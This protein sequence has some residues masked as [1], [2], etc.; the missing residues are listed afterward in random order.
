VTDTQPATQPCRRVAIR[1]YA[2]ASSPKIFSRTQ[3]AMSPKRL[4]ILWRFFHGYS[5]GLSALTSKLL[6]FATKFSIFWHIAPLRFLLVRKVEFAVSA[7]F[8]WLPNHTSVTFIYCSIS[9]SESML[10]TICIMIS[11]ISV[12]TW[13]KWGQLPPPRNRRQTRS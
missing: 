8:A 4:D 10:S 1:L 5:R 7:R 12:A 2:I 11:T 13:G 3:I 9:Y 6:D